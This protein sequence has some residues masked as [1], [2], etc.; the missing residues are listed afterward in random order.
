MLGT[1]DHLSPSA[2]ADSCPSMPAAHAAE[3]R[4]RSPGLSL[5]GAPQVP[6]GFPGTLHLPMAAPALCGALPH[7]DSMSP[8]VRVR[9]PLLSAPS[10]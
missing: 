1:H 10:T 7:L 2:A 9:V 4:E 8:A 5:A 6:P 3:T